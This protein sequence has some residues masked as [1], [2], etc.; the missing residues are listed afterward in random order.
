MQVTVIVMVTLQVYILLYSTR[1]HEKFRKSTWSLQKYRLKD[2]PR[3]L[4]FAK[5]LEMVIPNEF[6]LLSL[7]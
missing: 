7:S 5:Q 3:L 4:T 6:S 1:I 2:K